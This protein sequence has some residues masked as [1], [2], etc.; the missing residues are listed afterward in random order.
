M[1]IASLPLFKYFLWNC[2]AKLCTLCKF[3]SQPVFKME[4]CEEDMEI[5]EVN[6]GFVVHFLLYMTRKTETNLS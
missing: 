3:L 2:F 5:A 1:L 4:T 6:Q